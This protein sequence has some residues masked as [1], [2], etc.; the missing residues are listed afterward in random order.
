MAKYKCQSS[1]NAIFCIADWTSNSSWLR[2]VCIHT[3]LMTELISHSWCRSSLPSLSLYLTDFQIFRRPYGLLWVLSRLK[4]SCQWKCWCEKKM[5][6]E[7][8]KRNRITKKS[9]ERRNSLAFVDLSLRTINGKNGL[10]M[11]CRC[12][13]ADFVDETSIFLSSAST[14]N[15]EE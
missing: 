10:F 12:F 7:G 2:F 8:C 3:D 5:I 4:R 9:S 6:V 1:Y 13:C 15:M 11:F 14:I